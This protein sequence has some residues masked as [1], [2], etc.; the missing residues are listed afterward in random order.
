MDIVEMQVMLPGWFVSWW[1][2][3][4]DRVYS[5]CC[6]GGPEE[7]DCLGSLNAVIGHLGY[8]LIDKLRW[9]GVAWMNIDVLCTE[10]G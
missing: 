3:G 6:K 7:P 5:T 4:D 1:L 10:L 8:D 9:L 2:L